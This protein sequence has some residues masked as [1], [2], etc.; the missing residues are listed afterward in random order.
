LRDSLGNL[1]R[2]VGERLK[3]GQNRLAESGMRTA[4][5]ETELLQLASWFCAPLRGRPELAGLFAE[6]EQG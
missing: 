3:Q 4:Q 1:E 2:S 6:L 5:L